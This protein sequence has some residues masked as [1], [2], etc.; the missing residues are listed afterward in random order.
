MRGDFFMPTKKQGEK[1]TRKNQEG[2]YR[3]MKA[4]AW[5]C[6]AG[7]GVGLI[8]LCM[9]S[10]L[11]AAGKLPVWAGDAIGLVAGCVMAAAA[12]MVCA[13]VSGQNGFFLGM[14]CAAILFVGCLLCALAT[15]QQPDFWALIR[16]FS[17]LL[18]GCIFGSIGVNLRFRRA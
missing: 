17:M 11:M 12:A 8:L 16:L 3:K 13:R 1:Q 4:V 2:Q 6:L 9:I 5:G 7:I 15:G 18:C 10:A 14:G